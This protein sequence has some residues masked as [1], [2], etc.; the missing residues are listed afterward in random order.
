MATL[1]PS[2]ILTGTDRLCGSPKFE[3]AITYTRV[4]NIKPD[5]T[6]AFTAKAQALFL[7]GDYGE[8]IAYLRQGRDQEAKDRDQRALEINPGDLEIQQ[9]LQTLP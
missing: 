8:A 5:F 1:L 4:I 6:P 3:A 2:P 9:F 7:L